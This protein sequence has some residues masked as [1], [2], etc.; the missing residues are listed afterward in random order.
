M[1]D[2]ATTQIIGYRR[3]SSLDQ[4][5]DRQE[6]PDVTGK[7]FEEIKAALRKGFAKALEVDFEKGELSESEQKMAEELA[8]SKYGSKEW[9]FKR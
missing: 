8:E 1:A 4:K 6:L 2:T 7:V 9:N 3:V 5:L